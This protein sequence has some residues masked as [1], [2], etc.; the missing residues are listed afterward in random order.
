MSA[1]PVSTHSSE[2]VQS[3]TSTLVYDHEP[4][5]Q[6][7]SRVKALVRIRWPSV[8]EEDIAL[9]RMKGGS[10]N[11]IIGFSIQEA[12]KAERSEF[13]LRIPRF[14]SAQVLDDLAPLQFVHQLS[15][16]PVPE[17]VSFDCTT[18]NVLESQYM[19]LRR[20]QGSPLISLYP[21]MNHKL[22]CQTARQL[23]EAIACLTSLRSAHIGRLTTTSHEFGDQVDYLVRVLDGTAST[24][25]WHHDGAQANQGALEALL[26]IFNHRES[27]AMAKTP[28]DDFDAEYMQRFAAM[29]REMADMGYLKEVTI[30]LCHLDFEPRNFLIDM[31]NETTPLCGILDWDSAIF[32]PSFMSCTPPMWIWAWKDD[33]EEDERTANDTP[34]TKEG[35]ELKAIFEQAAGPIYMRFAYSPV[36]RLAR[37]LAKFACLGMGS[38]E[39]FKEAESMLEEWREMCHEVTHEITHQ[40]HDSDSEHD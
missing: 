40:Q 7:A 32:G 14:D 17:V 12:Y 10:F 28:V 15:D 22:R 35:C 30:S 33:E 26:Q 39:D 27:A 6:Y 1:S 4:F 8:A 13:V 31:Q 23:G 19:I 38:N 2:T 36:Y 18:N 37:R 21:E 20:L 25:A 3:E 34:E 11:R 5:E 29:T 9:E 16:L 24:A